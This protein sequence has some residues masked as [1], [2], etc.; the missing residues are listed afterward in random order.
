MGQRSL[1]QGAMTTDQPQLLG[2][3]VSFATQTIKHPKYKINKKISTQDHGPTIILSGGE[4]D[5][6]YNSQDSFESLDS[7]TVLTPVKL[8]SDN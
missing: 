3:S 1:C 7:P 6:R 4:Y 5:R 2:V 8:I